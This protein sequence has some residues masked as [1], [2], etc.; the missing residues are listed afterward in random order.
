MSLRLKLKNYRTINT[1]AGAETVERYPC[2]STSERGELEALS[3]LTY[4]LGLE[5]RELGGSVCGCNA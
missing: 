1:G 2:P 4:A 3:H 5:D